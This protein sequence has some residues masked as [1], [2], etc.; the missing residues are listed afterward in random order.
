MNWIDITRGYLMTTGILA[1][2]CYSIVII[3]L[4]GRGKK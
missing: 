3:Y 2:L 1:I 4:E